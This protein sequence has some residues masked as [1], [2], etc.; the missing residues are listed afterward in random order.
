MRFVHAM[1]VSVITL[2]L[3]I[4]FGIASIDP[5]NRDDDPTVPLIRSKLQ[6]PFDSAQLVRTCIYQRSQAFA[7][8]LME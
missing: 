4:P 3:Y 5:V 6:Y 7:K 8:K 1:R 2:H